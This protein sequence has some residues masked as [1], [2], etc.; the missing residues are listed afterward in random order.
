V[1]NEVTFEIRCPGCNLILIVDRV[2][3]KVL[4]QRKP[5]VE[6]STGDRFKDAFLRVEKL[7]ERV[8]SKVA[9]V[10]EREKTKM[11]RLNKLFDQSMKKKIE[12]GDTGPPS[13]PMD[14]D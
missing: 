10:K 5:L 13:R 8:E 1:S 12:E 2:T 7:G 3:G 9:Q 4:E 14:L 11:D 6:D